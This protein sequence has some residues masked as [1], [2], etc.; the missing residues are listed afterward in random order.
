MP[1]PEPIIDGD[2]FFTG[3]N[4]RLDPG[5]LQPGLCAFARN[6]RFITG[7]VAT[8]PGIKKMPWTNKAY[9][10]WEEKA[11]A[12]GDIVTYSGR[13]AV[14]K[15]STG[16]GLTGK[17]KI[18]A[19]NGEIS[20][21]GINL[22]SINDGG[23]GSGSTGWLTAAE[24]DSET[25]SGVGGLGGS[26]GWTIGDTAVHAA[27][28]G[29]DNLYQDIGSFLGCDYVLTVTI[30]QT[31]GNAG[32][33]KF[34]LGT[35]GYGTSTGSFVGYTQDGAGTTNDPFVGKYKPNVE[36]GGTVT[37]T[38]NLTAKGIRP[39]RLYIQATG[40]FAGTVDSIS[41][42]ET[43]TPEKVMLTNPIEIGGGVFKTSGPVSNNSL[44][45]GTTEQI[46]PF[47]QRA[48]SPDPGTEPPVA[49][50]TA[51]TNVSTLTS[52]WTSLGQRTY[53]YGTVYG[54]GIFRDPNSIEHLLVATSDG[55]YATKEGNP[56]RKLL[57]VSS[58]SQDVTFIQ[59]FN[60]VILLRGENLEPLVME[61]ISEGF[62]SI[63]PVVSDT[64]IDENDSDGTEQIPNASTGLFF[65]NR[66]LVPHQ[67]DLVAASDFL[68]YTRYQPIMANF[69]INQ[70]SEDELVKLV[71]IN[72]TTIACFKTNSIYI[73][74]NVYGNMSDLVLDEVTREYGAVGQNSIVQ[75]GSDVAFLS[76]KRGVTS[77]SIADNGK[78][79][80]VDVPIS[81]AIQPLIDRI[82]WNAA[83]GSA[84]AYH[85]NRL[86]M[87][88]PLDGSDYNNVILIYDFL[89][90]SW[91][92][93][94]DGEA[95]KVKQFLETI[96]QG[97]RRLF[98]L[99]TD[100]FINLYDDTLTD[101]GFVDEIPDPD[102]LG[103]LKVAQ[104]SDEVI[105]RGY[106]AGDIMV[107]KWKSA[108]LLLATNDPKFVVT[109][110]FEGPEENYLTVTP[111]NGK[112][113]SRVKY[114]RPFDKSDFTQSVVN[115]DFFTKFREDYSVGLSDE[116]NGVD[117]SLL[118][119]VCSNTAYTS[120]S[121]C[122]TYASGRTWTY[123]SL[124]NG[125][126]PDL[127]QRSSNKYK[128]RG[129]SRYVQLKVTNTNGRI[130]VIGTKVGAVPGEN[131]TNIK[132]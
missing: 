33:V 122:E 106:T 81:E 57:G 56:S 53:G 29:V 11:Y 15:A 132:T 102:N 20:F 71:R 36:V 88:V 24:T 89:M 61:R 26:S 117:I 76:S 87:A 97:K 127:H 60:V 54:S 41:M 22:L 113:F 8:R 116:T 79:T 25:N 12:S 50:Y 94:D 30:T 17:E 129:E 62:K 23:F 58:V 107:K 84:A 100:G 55:V 109:T 128:Y 110:Q 38:V 65:A 124:D 5:Q 114:D 27:V 67:K 119:G 105:T 93:Y 130:E 69:R 1:L 18:E 42:T 91:T 104:I 131:L 72:N 32:H 59:C 7:K 46:G 3:V 10:A 6:K 51:N 112:A 44:K 99:S 98:F 108:E 9:D 68:N 103:R 45:S 92:G 96:H 73:V 95:I 77:L 4:M 19:G 125:F 48:A 86:Y 63:T 43:S 115:N 2:T 74:S 39:N 35:T 85:N 13:G 123:N 64:D 14:I 52:G 28:S 80:A 101:C 75:V 66:L 16:G 82:N 111:T 40:D 90:K 121:T 34:L 70:G 118:T 37:Y 31:S 21:A 49:T 47:F 83:K 126:D 120:Q 78:V